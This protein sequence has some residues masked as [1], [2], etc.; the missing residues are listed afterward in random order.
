MK[1]LAVYECVISGGT[2]R[3]LIHL[4]K[5]WQ[6]KSDVWQVYCHQ[7][8]SGNELIKEK[9]KN[10]AQ[11]FFYGQEKS[12]PVNKIRRLFRLFNDFLR[13]YQYFKK[14]IK[15][16]RPDI[17]FFMQGG[18]PGAFSAHGAALAA[19]KVDKKIKI[20]MSIQNLP[21]MRGKK[22]FCEILDKYT[23]A[24]V[25]QFIFASKYT[26]REYKSKTDLRLRNSEIIPEGVEANPEDKKFVNNFDHINIGIIGAYEKRKGRD[27]LFKAVR[28]LIDKGINNFKILSYGQKEFGEFNHCLKLAKEL[29]IENYVG[30][31]D[32]E[33]NFD[34][35]Y[36]HLD[37][38]VQPSIDDES[39]PLVPIDAAAYYKPVI[40]SKLQGLQ[41]EIIHGQTGYL[42]DV[43]DSKAL[44]HYLKEL[45]LDK[46]LREQIGKNARKRYLENF[47][48]RKMAKRYYL[49]FKNAT[50]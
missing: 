21:S 38:V 23:N 19:K 14:Q 26:F 7:G 2:D 25:D 20:I 46:E 50:T 31:K 36:G 13:D 3:L 39:M 6:D 4:I 29:G 28:N 35:L 43:G 15:K 48:A 5:N 32:Y 27:I 47:T 24:N 33:K 34:K 37:I 30:W 8:N 42:F 16:S 17:V 45:I 22:L 1:I 44:T 18:Y 41:D 9:L 11:L 10:Y 49:I 40:A 12:L